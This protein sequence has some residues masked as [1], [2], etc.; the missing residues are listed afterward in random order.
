[1]VARL[2]GPRVSLGVTG[3]HLAGPRVY[4]G[5]RRRRRRRT[6]IT[7]T[8]TTTRTPPPVRSQVG[9]PPAGWDRVSRVELRST[10]DG[11]EMVTWTDGQP[12]TFTYP[13]PVDRLAWTVRPWLTRFP[14][15]QVTVTQ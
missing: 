15:E 10:P 9:E 5:G 2:R 12:E 13:V 3:F 14:P 6:T 7:V 11:S 8:T 1:M 4:F